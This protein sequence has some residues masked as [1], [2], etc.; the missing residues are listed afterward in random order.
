MDY[1]E[2]IG[3]LRK[4][5]GCNCECLDAATAIETLLEE[6]DKATEQ[7]LDIRATL[8]MYGGKYGITAAF[9]KAAERDAAVEML[10]GECHVCKHNVGWHNVGKCC[11]CKYEHAASMIPYEQRSDNW[12][13]RGPKKGDA[14]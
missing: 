5:D 3:K 7:L 2:L 6:R 11:T 4:K 14:Q 10:T 9:Q 12:E 8:D 1:E 13:W